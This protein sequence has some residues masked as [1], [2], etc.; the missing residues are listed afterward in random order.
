MKIKKTIAC[1]ALVSLSI[2]AH[3]GLW[4]WTS[5]SKANCFGVNKTVSWWQEHPQMR[6]TESVHYDNHKGVSH[7]V[8]T[9]WQM[10]DSQEAAHYKEW[11]GPRGDNWHVQGYN[12]YWDYYRGKKIYDWFTDAFDCNLVGDSR[13]DYIENHDYDD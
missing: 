4:R 1:V 8:T 13:D 2:S 6:L 3:A 7:M 12:Y 9:G 10:T 5:Y 11:E